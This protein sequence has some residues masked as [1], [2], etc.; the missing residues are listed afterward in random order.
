MVRRLVVGISGASGVI[1]G[2][3]LLEVLKDLKIETHLVLSPAAK[4][5]ITAE[6]DYT[7]VEVEKLASKVHKFS[8]ITASISSG[9]FLTDGMAIVPCSMHTLGAIAS[10]MADNLLTRAA[11]VTMKEYRKLVLA[12]RET[13]LSPIHLENMAKV[14][15]A[16]AIV[17]PT[18]PAFYPRPKKIEDIVDHLVGKVLDLFGIEHSL[19]KRWHGMNKHA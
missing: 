12:P 11:E 14:A 5:T 2:I 13:P 8:D 19:Y 16:G 1:Y 17:V 15:R 18:M 4:I 3:R 7:S 6:T 9:S 10:G